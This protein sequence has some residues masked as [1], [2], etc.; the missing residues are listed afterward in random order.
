MPEMR[1]YTRDWLT[2]RLTDGEVDALELA[3]AAQRSKLERSLPESVRP[4]VTG[5]G[6]GGFHDGVLLAATVGA[7]AT[8]VFCTGDLQRGYFMV[9][10]AFRDAVVAVR[11]R[12]LRRMVRRPFTELLYDEL[13]VRGD[14]YEW[15]AVFSDHTVVSVAFADVGIT[16]EPRADRYWGRRGP[17]LLSG[18]VHAVR[19]PFLRLYW[20]LR[21]RWSAAR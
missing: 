21:E 5:D 18:L 8:L 19:R 9:T 10:L 17:T 4:L 11:G 2:G 16:F 7:D 6:F 12:S 15:R 14:H 20:Q 3:A 1:Y 13:D